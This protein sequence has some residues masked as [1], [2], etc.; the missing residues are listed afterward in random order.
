MNQMI[1]NLVQQSHW[2]EQG[3]TDFMKFHSK[4]FTYT[5]IERIYLN[6]A[7]SY[8]VHWQQIEKASEYET[9]LYVGKIVTYLLIMSTLKSLKKM[10]P[11]EINIL[12]GKDFQNTLEEYFEYFQG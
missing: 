1:V 11:H 12:M 4:T 2:L 10:K 3:A 8:R 6:V 7:A 5:I 9:E